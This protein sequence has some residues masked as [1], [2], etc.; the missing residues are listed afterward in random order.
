MIDTHKNVIRYQIQHRLHGRNIILFDVYF[1]KVFNFNILIMIQY[2]GPSEKKTVEI[3]QVERTSA[4]YIYVWQTVKE[5]LSN[6]QHD[7]QMA[8]SPSIG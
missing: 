1:G 5:T 3:R 7:V 6:A 8:M 2:S 4:I